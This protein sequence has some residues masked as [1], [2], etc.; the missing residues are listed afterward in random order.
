ME[1]L[2]SLAEEVEIEKSQ[3]LQ[4]QRVQEPSKTRNYFSKAWQYTGQPV[5]RQAKREKDKVFEIGRTIRETFTLD[6][7][8][9][10]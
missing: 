7:A 1:S 3:V 10:S 6:Y 2:E 4:E 5:L 8:K 9:T